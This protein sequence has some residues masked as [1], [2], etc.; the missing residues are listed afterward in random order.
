[1][2]EIVVKK[3]G[4]INVEPLGNRVIILREESK[5]VTDGGIILPEESQKQEN[6]GVIV[7]V[8]PDVK[9]LEVGD[10]VVLPWGTGTTLEIRDQVAI[11]APEEEIL[12]RII[13]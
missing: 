12:V 8:G 1:M 4:K 5:D 9:V 2:E 6:E 13:D 10:R 11:V 3:K 7:S